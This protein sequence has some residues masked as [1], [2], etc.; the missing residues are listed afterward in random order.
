MNRDD[1]ALFMAK[2]DKEVNLATTTVAERVW[3]KLMP[4]MAEVIQKNTSIPPDSLPVEAKR[5]IGR[6]SHNWSLT[7][8]KKNSTTK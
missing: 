8:T 2:V 7:G 1:I 4:L 3:K 5:K 6:V